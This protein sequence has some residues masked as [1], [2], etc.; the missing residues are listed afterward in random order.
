M[1]EGTKLHTYE[2]AI[3]TGFQSSAALSRAFKQHFGTTIAD[4]REQATINS[5]VAHD[6]KTLAQ[7]KL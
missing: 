6:V 3:R 1:V 5:S 4:I 2:I 7:T